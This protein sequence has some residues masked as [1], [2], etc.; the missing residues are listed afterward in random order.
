MPVAKNA[1]SGSRLRFSNGRTATL[2]SEI[3]F[4]WPAMLVAGVVD[5]ARKNWN[6]SSPAAITA[7]AIVNATIF[8]PVSE[9]Q[10]GGGSFM[11]ALRDCVIASGHNQNARVAL[12]F[13]QSVAAEI[14]RACEDGRVSPVRS[15]RDTFVP[16]WH[17]G[18]LQRL[19]GKAPAYLVN[20]VLFREF[21]AY[22]TN[23]W[24]DAD[25]LTLFSK[26]TRWQLAHSD[27][28]PELDSPLSALDRF[29]LAL[30]EFVGN[31]FRWSCVVLVISGIGAWIFGLTKLL[32]GRWNY[33]FV[34]SAAALGSALAVLLLNLLVDALAFRNRGPTA[35]HEGY[36]LLVLFAGT[37]WTHLLS[38]R[39]A[40]LP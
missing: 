31:L 4:A 27:E 29:R 26:L 5:F 32:R 34:V 30:L 11:W 6:A 23:S 8:R 28:A 15:R 24:G 12:D 21:T 1:L 16:R 2:L 18:D 40:N 14:N 10:I 33:L 19:L 9:L 20:F 38:L 22:P 7:S 25:L 3:G 35:L 13:Y 39:N 36:P 37:A 17:A